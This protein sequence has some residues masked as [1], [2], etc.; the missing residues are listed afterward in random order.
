MHK[1]NDVWSSILKGAV[2]GLILAGLTFWL[3]SI[4]E[5]GD[6][7]VADDPLQIVDQVDADG[8]Q[9]APVHCFLLLAPGGESR[10][11]RYVVQV[12]QPNGLP[13]GDLETAAFVRLRLVRLIPPIGPPP[14]A[15]STE[16][17]DV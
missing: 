12:G 14:E 16:R 6:L 7:F 15:R 4:F 11:T 17:I 2:Y 10:N 13:A 1:P 5:P 9:V 3:V 8:L